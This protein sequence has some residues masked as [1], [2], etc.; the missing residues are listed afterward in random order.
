MATLS[1]P[2]DTFASVTL[3][4]SGAGQASI[5]PT[6]PGRV[7]TVSLLAVAT[8]TNKQIP[9]CYVYLGSVSPTTFL[10]GTANGARD[11][12]DPGVVLQ[13]SQR[14]IAVWANGDAG[15]IATMS[16]Y[17]TEQRGFW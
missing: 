3:N 10:G 8:S 2:L 16:L 7:W 15:A 5:G 6:Y 13:Q 11:Q 17:G 14:L 12:M 1:V 9:Q 4:S